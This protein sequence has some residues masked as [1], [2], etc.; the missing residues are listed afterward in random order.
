MPGGV[1]GLYEVPPA[2]GIWHRA[3][4]CDCGILG[5]CGHDAVQLVVR[6][7]CRIAG[8]VEVKDDPR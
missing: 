7:R 6:D 5:M 2:H 8:Q 1:L 4:L 3:L